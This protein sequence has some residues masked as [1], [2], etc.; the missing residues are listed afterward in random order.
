MATDTKRFVDDGW[1]VWTDENYKTAIYFTE[2]L[3]PRGENYVDVG[4][5]VYGMENPCDIHIFVP[6][7]VELSDIC[8]LSSVLSTT[9][10]AKAVFNTP[11]QAEKGAAGHCSRFV[12]DEKPV[13]LLHFSPDTLRL[14]RVADGTL[15]TARILEWKTEFQS[16]EIYVFFRLPHKSLNELF[17]AKPHTKLEKD[18][19][20]ELITSPIVTQRFG[21][22]LGVNEERILPQAILGNEKIRGQDIQ[23]TQLT[24]IIDEDYEVNDGGCNRIRHSDGSA[25]A[26]YAPAD[27]EKRNIVCYQ[28][29]QGRAGEKKSHSSFFTVIQNSFISRKSVLVYGLILMF[30]SILGSAAY[31][32]IKLLIES[33]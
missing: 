14:E 19:L 33:L 32:L 9:S 17:K 21:Y 30:T 28:W 13:D 6:F 22:T 16:D 5:W 31:D 1:S 10:G 27:F 24:L 15:L 20:K 26:G 7:P 18:S 11:F 3:N 4:V 23:R 29:R 2:W 8:D 12:Y 25:Y